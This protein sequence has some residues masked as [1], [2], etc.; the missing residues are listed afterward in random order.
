MEFQA[1]KGTCRSIPVVPKLVGEDARL[2]DKTQPFSWKL[3]SKNIVWKTLFT[4]ES[5]LI[6][7]GVS[8]V[9]IA[10]VDPLCKIEPS[11]SLPDW[12]LHRAGRFKEKCPDCQGIKRTRGCFTAELEG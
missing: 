8:S 5:Y 4:D 10:G 9:A 6:R 11:T 1:P 7:A 2:R 3:S 12:E